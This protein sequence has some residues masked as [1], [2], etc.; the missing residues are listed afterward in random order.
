MRWD[1]LFADLEAEWEAG[2]TAQ[3][4]A[5]AAELTRGEW[6]Q[7][8]LVERL[9]GAIGTVVRVRVRGVS[10]FELRVQ[11]V[12]SD[13]FGGA[14]SAGSVVVSLAH[15]LTIEAPLS[16]AV[17][18]ARAGRSFVSVL[19]LLARSRST[20]EVVAAGGDELAAGTI[21]RVGADHVDLARHA[22]DE[23]RRQASVRGRVTIPVAAIALV[24]ARSGVV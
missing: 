6:A 5:D 14:A 16:A 12:S 7:L 13:W 4:L 8:S 18:D 10:P 24:R 1:A 3:Q 17:V 9:R 21:D 2:R 22:R 19:R 15:M 23:P 20:V 11:A